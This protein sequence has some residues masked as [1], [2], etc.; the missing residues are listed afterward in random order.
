MNI[1]LIAAGLTTL[2]SW[3]AIAPATEPETQE[4]SVS[5]SA[6]ADFLDK[7]GSFSVRYPDGS[8]SVMIIADDGTFLGKWKTEE[9]PQRM[10][11]KVSLK[12]DGAVCYTSDEDESY[13]ACWITSELGADGNWRATSDKG[14]TV[15]IQQIPD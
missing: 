3:S 10:T 2:G 14:V 4:P 5:T 6:S 9:G 1:V 7:P 15:T 8:T 11:G 13:S 12:E